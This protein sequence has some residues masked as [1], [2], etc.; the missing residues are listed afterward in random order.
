MSEAERIVRLKAGDK[1]DEIIKDVREC[2]TYFLMEGGSDG[3][4]G[5]ILFH[6][7]YG[8]LMPEITDLAVEFGGQ[9]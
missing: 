9:V 8:H 7:N 1:A 3:T 2:A 4:F 6:E 5:H